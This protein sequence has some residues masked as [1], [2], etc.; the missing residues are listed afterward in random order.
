MKKRSK[1]A[2]PLQKETGK[3]WGSEILEPA[4]LEQ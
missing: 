4:P 2:L 1:A 3:G